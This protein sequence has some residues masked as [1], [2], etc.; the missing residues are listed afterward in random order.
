MRVV[1]VQDFASGLATDNKL[2]A[3]S[4]L[5]REPVPLGEIV[6]LMASARAL[7]D[8]ATLVSRE[9]DRVKDCYTLW[10]GVHAEFQA[11]CRAWEGVPQDGELVGQHRAHLR[12][13]LEL[14]ADRCELYTIT[15][16]ERREF[17][18]RRS[19]ET[20]TSFGEREFL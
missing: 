2:S 19:I 1:T 14:S 11:L 13:L 17:Q 16:A 6:E 7:Y 15:E 5:L 8:V 10:H 4:V 12:R 18:E 9:L 20:E 3:S